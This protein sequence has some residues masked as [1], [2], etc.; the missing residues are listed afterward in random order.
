MI[1]YG[2]VYCLNHLGC[3]HGY[4]EIY[5]EYEIK[6]TNPSPK[7]ILESVIPQT[8]LIITLSPIS[9]NYVVNLLAVVNPRLPGIGPVS[10]GEAFSTLTIA[11]AL[12][13]LWEFLNV[14]KFDFFS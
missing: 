10:C 1:H 13:Y 8:I 6:V 4:T 9:Y 14:A 7:L 2:S 11:L 12:S 5:D 3:D